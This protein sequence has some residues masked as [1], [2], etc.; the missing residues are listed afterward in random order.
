MVTQRP[1]G[2]TAVDSRAAGGSGKYREPGARTAGQRDDALPGEPVVIAQDTADQHD[3]ARFGGPG[4][5]ARDR[6]QNARQ[7]G[8]AA[9]QRT[10]YAEDIPAYPTPAADG[11]TSLMRPSCSD[12]TTT[13][14]LE[15]AIRAAAKIGNNS[16]LA[17][18][19]SA[20]T[21]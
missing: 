15:P 10:H 16:P 21:L 8:G 13:R 6:Q 20:T 1:H 19:D 14:R 12:L 11:G 3:G 4:S 2:E 17:A 5:S 9:F 18:R 7:Q